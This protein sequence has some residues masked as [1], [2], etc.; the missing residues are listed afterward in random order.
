MPPLIF[1]VPFDFSW[2]EFIC[3]ICHQ[4]KPKNVACC[5]IKALGQ[6]GVRNSGRSQVS[7]DSKRKVPGY[8][9]GTGKGPIACPGP[10]ASSLW[11]GKVSQPDSV[12]VHT[13]AYTSFLTIHQ[14]REYWSLHKAWKV[15]TS[16]FFNVYLPWVLYCTHLILIEINT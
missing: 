5:V 7:Q 3:L 11:Y 15:H 2:T 12:I 1:K 14:S 4:V 10:E 13:A 8:Q 16:I 6:G 9:Q